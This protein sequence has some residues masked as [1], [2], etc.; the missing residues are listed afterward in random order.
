[1][2]NRKRTSPTA[3]GFVL[4]AVAVFST[5]A[6]PAA[7]AQTADDLATEDVSFSS[8]DGVVLHGTIVSPPDSSSS[9]PG[10]VLVH[11]GGAATR[12]WHRQEAEAFARAGIAVLIY[13]KRTDGYSLTE[14]SYAQ[15]ADDA[16]A[17]HEVLRS[18]GGV[19]RNRV[20]LWGV[21]EGGW[22]APLAA[23]N[24]DDVA[25]LIT[26]GANGIPPAQQEAWAKSNRLRRVGVSGSM[27]HSYTT[28]ALRALT[29]AGL[30]PEADYDPIPVLE[31]LNQ[32]MLGIWGEFEQVSPPAENLLIFVE[33]LDRGAGASYTLKILADGDHAAYVT[34]D[35]GFATEDWINTGGVFASGYV[36]LVGSWIHGLSDGPPTSSADTP[37]A[38]ETTSTPLLPLDWYESLAVQVA[39]VSLFVV[40]FAGYLLGG[41][42]RRFRGQRQTHPAAR[43]A[44]WLATIGL[45]TVFGSLGYFG[46]MLVTSEAVVG[47]VVL[48]R[49]LPW[50]TLQILAL[51]VVVGAVAT[52]VI[53]W[54]SRSDTHGSR[55]VWF[56]LL[57][58]AATLFVPWALYWGLLLP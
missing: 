26:V 6:Q 4:V 47:S 52:T 53:W 30:F 20:G 35:G 10:L 44:F 1:M 17:A 58:T 51:G 32:P 45:V 42:I 34:P 15:L 57:T 5:L 37:P 18:H 46:I 36:E 50:I 8:T 19:D 7:G 38:Q 31:K 21:S 3:A 24:S 29:A 27:L 54:R 9:L 39:L 2:A 56:P 13:D 23:S 16:L 33:A 55:P 41:L 14:R 28:T 49:T 22:V 25:F 43:A 11:G 48:G 40:A 12:D